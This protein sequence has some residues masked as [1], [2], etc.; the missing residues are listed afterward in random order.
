MG[1]KMKRSEALEAIKLELEDLRMENYFDEK[2]AE[3]C[4]NLLLMK[5][6]ELGMMPP[7]R[8]PELTPYG[9]PNGFSIGEYSW[10]K[11]VDE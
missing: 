6:D 4:A 8:V 9:E 7:L 1:E 3:W 11:E 2:G 10:E 5:I